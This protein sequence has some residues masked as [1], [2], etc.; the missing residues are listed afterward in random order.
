MTE[1]ILVFCDTQKVSVRKQHVVQR[2]TNP[3]DGKII[4]L[5]SALLH[6]AINVCSGS[7]FKNGRKSEPLHVPRLLGLG[8]GHGIKPRFEDESL[9]IHSSCQDEEAAQFSQA[10]HSRVLTLVCC[11]CCCCC[12]GCWKGGSLQAAAEGCG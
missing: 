1:C 3:V 7:H 10:C 8:Q 6:A 11:C 9:K 2:F 4:W 5:P 12:W